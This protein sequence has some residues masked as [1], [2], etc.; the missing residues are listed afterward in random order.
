MNNKLLFLDIDG[1]LTEPGFNTPPDSAL[2]AVRMAQ[3][4]G[5][6]VFLCSGRNVAMLSP[7]LKFGFDGYVASA[8]G[9]VVCDD[10][11][12]FDRPMK[13]E[14]FRI[15][16]DC[17]EKNHVFRTVEC[18]DGTYGDEG[19][20]ELLEGADEFS[21][22]ELLR[23]RRQ[24]S[25]TLDIR[26]MNE[27]NGAPVYKIVFMCT[28]S[29]QLREP[30]ELLKNDFLFCV[31]NL[32]AVGCL[33]GEI[34]GLDFNKGIGIQKICEFLG[35]DMTDTIGFGDSMNDKEMFEVV[36]YSVCMSN[37]HQVMKEMADYVCPSVSEDGLYKAFETLGL[38]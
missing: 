10:K 36:G 2:K 14:L 20:G 29:E 38:I 33:N 23:F 15:A 34:I 5:H 19:L 32:D 8:G 16:M 1:T 27:Y 7:L 28:K 25:E 13:P 31:Q 18:L 3:E 24:L 12:V 22:S 17:F 9:Y 30:M 4:N 26:P 35:K 37:G 11:V 21:N 6:K